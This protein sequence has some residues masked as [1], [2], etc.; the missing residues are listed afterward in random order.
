MGQRVEVIVLNIR[1]STTGK[2]RAD[3]TR[4]QSGPYCPPAS[5]ARTASAPVSE[6]AIE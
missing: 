2:C 5:A 1:K 6:L 4:R 3:K